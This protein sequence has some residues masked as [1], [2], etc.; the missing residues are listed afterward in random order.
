MKKVLAFVLAFVLV[1]AVSGCGKKENSGNSQS[2][3]GGNN[4]AGNAVAGNNEAGL[5]FSSAGDMISFRVASQIKLNEDAWLGFIPGNVK[6]KEEAEAD[7]YDVLYAYICNEDKKEAEDYRF[8]FSLEQ[9]DGLDDGD[10]TIV[11]CDSDSE[12]KVVLYFPAAVKGSV[13]T[14]DFD[15]LT[16]N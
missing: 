9:I 1:L 8:E 3:A 16:M 10:Y 13:V 7:E 12:G 5:F 4:E 15:K 2:A 11:L 6:Y 14:P